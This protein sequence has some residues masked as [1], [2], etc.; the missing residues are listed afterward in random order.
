MSDQATELLILEA[1]KHSGKTLVIADENTLHSMSLLVAIP[2]L[3]LYTNRYDVHETAQALGITPALFGDLALN[4]LDSGSFDTIAFRCSKEKL[5]SHH[6]INQSF[7]LLKAD[8]KLLLAGNKN[9]GIKSLIENAGKAYGEKA[10]AQKSGNQYYGVI[11]KHANLKPLKDED[12]PALRPTIPAKPEQRVYNDLVSK[13][14]I[15]GWKKI[16]QGSLFL[17]DTLIPLLQDK[18]KDNL[19]GIDLGCGWGHLSAALLEEVP[20]SRWVATDNNAAAIMACTEN[21]KIFP[22]AEV[23]ADDCG[24]KIRE[25][26]HLVVSNPPFHQGFSVDSQLTQ[27][28]IRSAHSHLKPNGQAVF[29]VNSFIGVEKAGTGLFGNIET[30][31]NNGSFKV[32]RF[33]VPLKK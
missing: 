27:K 26:F 7:D 28:F 9:E 6:V 14:G 8:G 11:S 3:T 31:A 10:K 23:I 32:I 21:L 18:P 17:L 30:L 20:I 15:F 25:R 12:Y 33:S 2:D 19:S 29:V 13:P 22:Q 1:R 5:V 24:R 16:D 4:T